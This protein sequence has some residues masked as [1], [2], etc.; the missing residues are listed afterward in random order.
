MNSTKSGLLI[1]LLIV[2]MILS[3]SSL[4]IVTE[5]QQAIRTQ[6]G[7]PIGKPNIHAGLH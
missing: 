2:V 1:L 7:R 4:Y 5:G 6:F 3:Y